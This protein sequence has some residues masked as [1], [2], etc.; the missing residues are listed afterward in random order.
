MSALL[1]IIQKYEYP[2]W[3][4]QKFSG[5][6]A[7]ALNTV[8]IQSID[9]YTHTHSILY[10]IESRYRERCVKKEKKKRKFWHKKSFIYQYM[11]IVIR[12][13]VS[14]IRWKL[15]DKNRWRSQR[16]DSECVVCAFS[17]RS[18]SQFHVCS[19]LSITCAFEQYVFVDCI[20]NRLRHE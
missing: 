9:R 4:H 1:Y 2:I 15:D 5:L 6:L 10:H 3:V 19:Y 14:L 17:L 16:R 20:R 7:A 18:E 8:H 12:D 13:I 11:V